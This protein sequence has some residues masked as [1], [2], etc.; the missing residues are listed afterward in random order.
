[1]NEIE[2]GSQLIA[3]LSVIILVGFV[4][5]L[6]LLVISRKN[7]KNSYDALKNDAQVLENRISSLQESNTQLSRFQCCIDAEAEAEAI[8]SSAEKKATD[9]INDAKYKASQIIHEASEAKTQSEQEALQIVA[10]AKEKIENTQAICEENL[11][12]SLRKCSE[13]IA[14][15]E[16]KARSIAGEAYDI[17]QKA[18]Y[19]RQV[20]SAMKNIIQGYG[21]S[22]LK[23]TESL[24][25]SLANEFGFDDA[26][27]ELILA[28]NIS[29]KMITEGLAA[30]CDYV[31]SYRR[32]TAIEFILDA[33]N[34]KVDS[35]L[36]R[37]KKD[38]YGIL[39]QKI[40]DAYA[41]VNYLGQAFRNARITEEYLSA[42]LIELKW[43]V[44]V[45]ALKEKAKE[46]QRRIKE[47]MR[48]EERARREYERA[49]KDAAKDE[50][51]LRKA[52]EKARSEIAKAND[53]QKAK[54]EA[55]LL[56]LE[57]KL[58]EAEARSQRAM[59]MAQQTRRGHVYI[60]S[61][62]GSFGEDVYKI[63]MTR[64]LEPLDRVRELGDASVPFPFDVHAMIFSDDA[65]TLESELHRLFA[66]NQLNKVNPRKEFFRVNISDIKNV[67]DKKNKNVSWTLTAQAAQYRESL[68][69]EASW[70]NDKEAESMWEKTQI[71]NSDYSR[72]Y[73]ED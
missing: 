73:I 13:L 35:I 60:I 53:L 61:N 19:Y 18:D 41:T 58:Q 3:G 69:I 47:Q 64:R 27:R 22:Y 21:N 11:S 43:G 50:E 34:G 20:A 72:I 42:R 15:A 32:K 12:A 65:P 17:A 59:S 1:M 71:D 68:A 45:M 40:R 67:I 9:Y 62:I 39:E 36:S 57:Q 70:G 16:A 52:M 28:R 63:G 2:L 48:E 46:E 29:Q 25:D 26:G 6:V 10:E 23:P 31:E 51:T 5:L 54:Y 4:M 37:L 44:A 56:E 38:N 24:L 49:I 66:R 8:K 55:K 30:T 14:G 33:F 7:L